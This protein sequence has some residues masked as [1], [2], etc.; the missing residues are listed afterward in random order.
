MKKIFTNKTDIKISLV[1]ALIGAIGIIFATLSLGDSIS[2]EVFQGTSKTQLMVIQAIQTL[3]ISLILSF[4]GLK[5]ARAVNINKGFLGYVQCDKLSKEDKYH[6]NFKSVLLALLV[7]F[8][9]AGVIVLSEKFVWSR[10]IEEIAN[11]TFS[12][13]PLYL[14]AGMIS[15]GIGEEVTLRLFFMSFIT[16]ILYKVFARKCE[17]DN[18]PSSVYWIAIVISALVFALA[19]LPA[20]YQ[21]F[22]VTTPIIIRVILLNSFGGILYGYLYWKKGLEYAMIAHMFTH[23]FMQLFWAPILL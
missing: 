2:E 11:A 15:G 13:N 16:F 19:H 7:A 14:L 9:T 12:F 8:I 20:T 1:L 4:I 23:V 5:L 6:I 17:K 10:L 3:I 21:T 22:N 18:I